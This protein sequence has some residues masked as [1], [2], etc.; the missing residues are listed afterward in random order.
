MDEVLKFVTLPWSLKKNAKK[1]LSKKKRKKV[2][3]Q[4]NAKNKRTGG[5]KLNY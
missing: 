1:F 2:F 4:K 3:E 5:H